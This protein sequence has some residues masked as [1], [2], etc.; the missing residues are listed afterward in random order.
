MTKHTKSKW[1]KDQLSQR[2]KLTKKLGQGG[3]GVVYQTSDPQLLV[4][5]PLKNFEEI[6]D[7]TEITRFQEQLERLFLLPLSESMHITKPLYLLDGQ[8]GYVMQMMEDM[9]PIGEWLPQIFKQQSSEESKQQDSDNSS[10]PVWF[11]HWLSDE[12]PLGSAYPLAMYAK[13]GGTKRRLE[14]LTQATIE[15]LKLHSV[16]VIFMDISPENLFCSKTKGYNEVW[17]IDADNLRFEAIDAKAGALTPQYAAPEVV[18]RES[19]ARVTSDAYSLSLLAFKVLTMCGA[20]EGIRFVDDEDDWATDDSESGELSVEVQAEH[21]LLPFIFDAEDDSNTPIKGRGLPHEYILTPELLTFFQKMFGKGRI[22]PWQRPSLHSLPRMLAKATDNSI[23]CSCGMSFYHQPSLE[24]NVCPYCEKQ[25]QNLI[26]ATSYQYSDEGIGEPI[27][28]WVSSFSEDEDL[29]L[30]RRL[31]GSFE[32][33][34]HSMPL[35]EISHIESDSFIYVSAEDVR[36]DITELYGR[37]TPLASQW[38][39]EKSQ[40]E[41]GVQLYV[42]AP[43]SVIIEIKVLNNNA[44]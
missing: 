3:Q 15:L 2:H 35:L 23:Q 5:M 1:V 31:I 12:V 7:P 9:Q 34:K 32:F 37:F 33:N 30:P 4:K 26:V 11:P 16:G 43:H 41:E 19:G 44:I 24:N 14:L 22:Q 8:A 36:I 13:S 25:P 20:F 28:A 40:L 21:G 29:K 10:S 27:W 38:L 6:I 17:L 18:K 42:H 39:L